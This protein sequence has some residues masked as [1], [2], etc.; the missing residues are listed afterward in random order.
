MAGVCS[1]LDSAL[2]SWKDYPAGFKKEGSPKQ[3]CTRARAELVLIKHFGEIWSI[4][5]KQRK[6]FCLLIQVWGELQKW[7]KEQRLVLILPAPVYLFLCKGSLLEVMYLKSHCSTMLGFNFV[8]YSLDTIMN[9]F[10]LTHSV[11][12]FL[13]KL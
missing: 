6:G 9:Y 12:N 7:I 5:L 11:I 2:S 10:F 8:T 1:G 3:L 13:L 4:A